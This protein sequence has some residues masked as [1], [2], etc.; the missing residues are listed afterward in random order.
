MDSLIDFQAK[1]TELQFRF[2]SKMKELLRGKQYGGG[3]G[4]GTKSSM[5]LDFKNL[6][7]IHTSL[8]SLSAH[9][10]GTSLVARK[11]KLCRKGTFVLSASE[12]EIHSKGESIASVKSI[13]AEQSPD[14]FSNASCHNL[15]LHCQNVPHLYDDV[16]S[17]E[18]SNQSDH[19]LEFGL[20]KV[21]LDFEGKA[22][23]KMH[24]SEL[25]LNCCK[26]QL[27][28]LHFLEVSRET[29]GF[30][31]SLKNVDILASPEELSNLLNITKSIR[32]SLSSPAY[33]GH[34]TTG[35]SIPSFT[36]CIV[37]NAKSV[38]VTLLS[39]LALGKLTFS[40]PNFALKAALYPSRE[41]SIYIKS[42][43]VVEPDNRYL[44]ADS[45]K[46]I[47]ISKTVSKVQLTV[48]GPIR[49]NWFAYVHQLTDSLLKSFKDIMINTDA[50]KSS[51]STLLPK[52]K[53]K[54]EVYIDLGHELLFNMHLETQCLVFMTKS[55]ILSL[56]K[57]NETLLQVP[58][59]VMGLKSHPN[60]VR[61]S[62]LS[63]TFE[64]KSSEARCDIENPVSSSNACYKI[65]LYS[66]EIAVPF[67]VD[68]HHAISNEF[69][70]VIKWL[71]QLHS[72]K[73][74][75]KV[76]KERIAADI[77]IYMKNFSLLLSDDPF[78]VKLRENFE[79]IEDEYLEA[80]KRERFLDSKIEELR[81]THITLPTAKVKDDHSLFSTRKKKINVP[82]YSI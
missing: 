59:I 11:L 30:G 13:G 6:P 45:E 20:K 32:K 43:S 82:F 60:I 3:G 19:S 57:D 54:L 1:S 46:A 18:K 41:V 9:S 72:S 50:S 74:S 16:P 81:K 29:D 37:V 67:Q 26:S 8:G 15:K 55:V 66:C 62:Q 69:L 75:P 76:A 42:F 64:E 28:L 25:E 61:L 10:C 48:K 65:T 34:E 58:Y 17:K 27:V 71:R 79:L 2:I 53:E 47:L 23:K 77:L 4:G 56:E 70:G 24:L 14:G 49:C 31:F 12:V 80:A 73:S 5:K 33:S 51:S 52:P 44:I 21:S 68:V 35:S 40:T 63:I 78:E 39:K 7:E 38:R 36:R 22:L